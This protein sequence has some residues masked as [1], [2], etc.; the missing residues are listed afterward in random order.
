MLNG[1]CHVKFGLVWRK[2]GGPRYSCHC[3][4]CG[5]K[6]TAHREKITHY[7]KRILLVYSGRNTKVAWFKIKQYVRSRTRVPRPKLYKI[8]NLT[9][10]L[11]CT[12]ALT[13]RAVFIYSPRVNFLSSPNLAYI[14]LCTIKIYIYTSIHLSF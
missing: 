14:Y 7:K 13:Q 3:W 9:S 1:K 2:R 12:E 6:C 4:S 5:Q 10:S 11:K 8:E